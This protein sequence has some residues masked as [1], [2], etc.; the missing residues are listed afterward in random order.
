MGNQRIGGQ[1]I[2]SVLKSPRTKVRPGEMDIVL[3]VDS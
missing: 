1:V 2:K 3:W